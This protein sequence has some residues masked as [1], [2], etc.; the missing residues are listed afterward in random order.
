MPESNFAFSETNKKRIYNAVAE[1]MNR[2]GFESI[3]DA[4]LIIKIQGGTSREIENRRPTFY[5]P[6]GY[7]YG[8]GYPYSYYRDP[9]M[10]DDISRK[11][12]ML[13]IDILDAESKQLLWQGTGYGVLS[14]KPEQVEANL[15]RAI[16]DIFSQ[17]PV[18]P[19]PGK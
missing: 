11:T 18:D 16:A 12:T 3:Q 9:W 13:I 1:E 4:D 19:Q 2:R 17:F 8:Y 10:F 15:R 7:G 5:D 14:E 6:Y